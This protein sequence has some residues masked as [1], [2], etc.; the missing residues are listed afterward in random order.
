MLHTKLCELLKIEYPIIQVGMGPFTS[1]ELVTAVS[2]AGGLGILGITNR[3]IES[4]ASEINRVK[5]LTDHPFG[6]NYLFTN[7]TEEAF[8]L[9]LQLKVPL[10]STSLGD[11]GKLVR[12]V[13]DAGALY[14]HQ[15][16]TMS[17]AK[18]AKERGVDIII[19]QGSEAGGYRQ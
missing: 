6:V 7:Y 3:P 5:Q 19:A 1:V 12:R 17:H 9:G 14:M 4:L 8:E 10:I 13:H 15:V 11:S 18:Q 16:H 2:N